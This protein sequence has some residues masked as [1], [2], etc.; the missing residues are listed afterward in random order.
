MG[1]F[2]RN[3]RW[4]LLHS[5]MAFK[6]TIATHHH[7]TLNEQVESALQ[8]APMRIRRFRQSLDLTQAD[9]SESLSLDPTTV[10]RMERGLTLPSFRTV[11]AI[12][13]LSK[14]Q[15][16]RQFVFDSIQDRRAPIGFSISLPMP[17][18]E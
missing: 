8:Q 10:Y 13:F 6:D 2:R 4:E 7:S 14:N 18:E 5:A 12:H 3:L 17:S 11:L 1:F 9:F 16:L 15:G